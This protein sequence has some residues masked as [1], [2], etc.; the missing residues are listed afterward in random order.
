MTLRPL[1]LPSLLLFAL[2][3][4]C[5]SDSSE[6]AESAGSGADAADGQGETDGSGSGASADTSTEADAGSGDTGT[7]ED[8]AESADTTTDSGS[9]SGDA[10]VEDT[11]VEPDSSADAEPDGSGAPLLPLPGFGTITGPCGVI[12]AQL[13][14]PDPS[15][16]VNA[17]DFGTDPWDNP[18]DLGLL[19]SGGQEMVADGNAGG[20]SLESE[21][22]SLE[23]LTRCE[24]ATLV[25]TET[26]VVYDVSGSITDILVEIDGMKVGV[27]VTRAV[28]FPR[29]AAYTEATASALLTRKLA[30]I[31]ESTAN[32]SAGDR[33][34]K[35]ILHVIAYA[36]QHVAAMQAAYAALDP[37]VK[38][39]TILWVTR[40]DGDDEF[41]Y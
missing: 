21:I 19:T 35:Q 7:S 6:K 18:A 22:F 34:V 38:A 4:A 28:G 11:S 13:L 15:V 16:I 25:K 29:D 30:G 2:L 8:T 17:I 14:S 12:D 39:D 32:V 41:I 40:S 1:R 3:A 9:G 27:S 26:E 24:G 5:S 20:S 10:T 36:D 31:Q 37:S 23:V 33:W